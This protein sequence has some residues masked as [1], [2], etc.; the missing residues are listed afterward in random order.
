M[1]KADICFS[2][3]QARAFDLKLLPC[4]SSKLTSCKINKAEKRSK[5][6]VKKPKRFAEEF[7][8]SMTAKKTEARKRYEKLY[9][10]EV[11]KVNKRI[12]IHFK[13]YSTQFDEWRFFG[14]DAPFKCHF[15]NRICLQYT[16]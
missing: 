10:V 1:L 3:A 15:L 12:K 5:R 6:V 2:D 14:G 16:L 9:D 8:Q 4:M 11:D 7:R 13:G